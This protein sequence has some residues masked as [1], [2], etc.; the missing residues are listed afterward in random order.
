MSKSKKIRGKD[1]PTNEVLREKYFNY[2][3]H[4]YQSRKM[5][6]SSLNYFFEQTIQNKREKKN[7]PGYAYSGHI[8]DLTT[9]KL[10]DYFVWLKNLDTI[11][12][13]TKQN[14]W[15]ILT[16]F[17]ESVMEDHG[18]FRVIIPKKSINWSGTPQK[19]GKVISNKDVYAI[20]E[21]LQAILNFLKKANFKHYLIV[22]LLIET[23]ARKGEIVNLK[24]P[25]LNIKERYINVHVGKTDEKYYFFSDELGKYL[26]LYLI[27]R[28]KI[29]S[30]DENLFLTRS[31]VKYS[32]RA[33]N[34]ILEN[35][36]KRVNIEKNITC[37]TLR[38]TLND[39]RKEMECPNED[40]KILIGHKVFDVNVANYTKSDINRNRK[41]YDTW[42][43]YRNLSF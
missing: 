12:I 22:R 17:L 14:K 33:F 23:G 21:E 40:R 1:R 13:K 24:M 25:E 11:N 16:S 10:K 29:K 38:K 35:A 8:F 26:E 3:Q 32:N 7:Y 42:N 27:E 34:S 15:H 39:F 43:P 36:C 4:S 41:L 6:E 28:E 19:N 37:Q 18:E 20:K 31:S 30:E 9:E 2:Y 5:R